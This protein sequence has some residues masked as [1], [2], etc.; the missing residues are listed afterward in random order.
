MAEHPDFN[1]LPQ[2]DATRGVLATVPRY[3]AFTTY[4]RWLAGQGIEFREIAGNS[5][6]VVVSLLLPTHWKGV[7][8]ASRL[9]FTQAILT[10][11]GT[12]RVVLAT[13]VAQLGRLL[14]QV[15]SQLGPSAI[16]HVYD[17]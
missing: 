2:T 10:R 12:H 15:E 4:S 9:L 13:P 8:A 11:P 14:R 6:D 16:E 17:F 3:E 7:G 1:R 5:G